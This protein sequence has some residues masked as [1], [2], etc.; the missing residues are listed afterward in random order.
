MSCFIEEFKLMSDLS[1]RGMRETAISLLPKDKARR[2]E[3]YQEL[4]RGTG[5]LDDD[6]HLNMY[7]H[8]FGRMHKAKLDTAFKTLP[9]ADIF[10]EKIEIYDWGCGQ[11]TAVI[12]L[13]DY[14]FTTKIESC[15]SKISLIEPSK[16]AVERAAGVIKCINS[17][18]V[19]SPIVKDFD[20][21]DFGDFKKSTTRKIHL[22]SNILDV[23]GFDLVRF[24]HLFQHQ[25][26]GDNYFIC[27]G[28]YYYNNRRVDEFL[29][30]SLPDTTYAI[31][32]KERG[33]W[34]NDWT[35][36]MRTFFKRFDFTESIEDIRQRIEDSRK[37]EQFFAGY[38]LDAITEEYAKS[39]L[40]DISESLYNSLSVFD[41]KSNIPLGSHKNI[42]P[43]LAVLG[44]IISR[45][46]PTKAPIY[47][48]NIFS[49][50]YKISIKPD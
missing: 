15:I 4:K 9:I 8:S 42:D 20:S 36:S 27:V 33:R 38:V 29:A 45:G 39:D 25:F 16:A 18:L 3:L 40:K 14:L 44:N 17:S 43:I 5:I 11:G 21:L 7:L 6:D 28:P 47:V 34:Q 46:L 31:I 26:R 50:L 2:D 49:D 1:F 24:I 48:E 22:F 23:E 19:I 35:I 30:A 10:S 32:N 13:L 41:V 12:C 37:K